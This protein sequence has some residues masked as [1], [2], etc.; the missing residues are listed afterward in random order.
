MKTL[1]R[2]EMTHG[3]SF[4]GKGL[5]CAGEVG[6]RVLSHDSLIYVFIMWETRLIDSLFY[7]N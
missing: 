1:E 5:S 4:Q 7:L 3:R 6:R 2:Y